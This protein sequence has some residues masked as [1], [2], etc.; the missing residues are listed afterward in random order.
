M[1]KKNNTRIIG[2]NVSRLD[3]SDALKAYEVIAGQTDGLLAILVFQ[4][5]RYEAGAG[6]VFWVKDRSGAEVPV[7]SARYS[8]WENKNS[9]TRC[10]TPAKIAREIRQ[11]IEN[12]PASEMPRYDW[13]IAH[14]WSWFKSS[15]GND[16]TAENIPQQNAAENCGTRGYSPVMWCA[17]RLPSNIRIVSPEELIWRIRMKHDPGQTKKLIQDWQQ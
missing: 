2:F 17:A 12:T 14:A 10:G 3:S 4:Y 16:E 6:K 15:P 1:M 8:I 13:V 5:D 7:I 11:S 9:R